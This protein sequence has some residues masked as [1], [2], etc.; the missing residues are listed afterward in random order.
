MAPR[1]ISV[2]SGNFV[3]SPCSTV[4]SAMK[5]TAPSCSYGSLVAGAVPSREV[6]S[7][8][9]SLELS[10]EKGGVHQIVDSDIDAA[11]SVDQEM[12]VT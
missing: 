11:D 1:S 9:N 3:S 4:S 12:V 8:E 2:R 5:G 7:T 6:V 10:C